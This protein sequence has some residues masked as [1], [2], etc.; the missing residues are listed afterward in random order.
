MRRDQ[1]VCIARLSVRHIVQIFGDRALQSKL[2]FV[3]L[4]IIQLI[5]TFSQRV[6]DC[7]TKRVDWYALVYLDQLSPQSSQAPV[8][9]PG[10]RRH[11][12]A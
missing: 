12:P 1:A 6:N 5:H 10:H 4:G 9:Q 7:P 2:E 11:T 8:H 3:C